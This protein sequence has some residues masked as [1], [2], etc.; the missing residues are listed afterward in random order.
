VP[1]GD[2]E[3]F[4]GPDKGVEAEGEEGVVMDLEGGLVGEEGAEVVEGDPGGGVGAAV[5]A[6]VGTEAEGGEGGGGGRD[7]IDFAPE[8]EGGGGTVGPPKGRAL[9][10]AVEDELVEGV[11]G[12]GG[13]VAGGAEKDIIAEARGI[14]GV[15]RR[16]DSGE[17]KLCRW[18]ER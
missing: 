18:G 8:L 17:G 6:S 1:P 15:G 13:D 9:L 14:G 4:T 5:G 7:T 16:S 2:G 10:V 3:D 11:R 12:D